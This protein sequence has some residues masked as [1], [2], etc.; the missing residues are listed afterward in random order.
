MCENKLKLCQI[1]YYSILYLSI[2]IYFSFVKNRFFSFSIFSLYFLLSHLFRDL[3][4]LFQCMIIN[5]SHYIQVQN[6][7]MLNSYPMPL[8][9]LPA[10][11]VH[12]GHY[13]SYHMFLS[14]SVF[15]LGRDQCCIFLF[16]ELLKEIMAPVLLISLLLPKMFKIFDIYRQIYKERC[17]QKHFIGWSCGAD[18]SDPEKEIQLQPLLC[19]SKNYIASSLGRTIFPSLPL[20]T[21]VQHF[22]QG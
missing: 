15:I 7:D 11:S 12:S 14:H 3:H 8:Y 19:L 5:V 1:N 2:Y 21:C 9:S 16:R 17:W 10:G 4:H 20:F 13:P 18:R 6:Y 22:V